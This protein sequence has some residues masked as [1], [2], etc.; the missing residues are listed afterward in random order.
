MIK[1]VKFAELPVSNQDWAVSFYTEKVG[2]KV[3]RDSPYKD[4]WRWIELEILYAE[5]RIMLTER[6]AREKGSDPF[7]F[8]FFFSFFCFCFSFLAQP[9]RSRILSWRARPAG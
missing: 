8:S 6:P 9:R 4:G 2:L 5:T 3:V 7:F 1:F